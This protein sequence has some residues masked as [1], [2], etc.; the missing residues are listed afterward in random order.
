MF[1]IIGLI[2]AFFALI[3]AAEIAT[4]VGKDEKGKRSWKKAG[5]HL[6]FI[7][8]C[9]VAAGALVYL[10][11]HHWNAI[12]HSLIWLVHGLGAFTVFMLL[13]TFGIIIHK[14]SSLPKTD[15]L[16]SKRR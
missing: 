4:E 1:A 7:G 5:I 3:T 2:D 10:I 6:A 11:Q 9:L 14:R 16:P 12:T 13:W 15:R 8:I